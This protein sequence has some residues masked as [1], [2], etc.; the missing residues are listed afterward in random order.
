M[1]VRLFVRPS[2]PSL[3]RA[4]IIHLLADRM[5]SGQSQVNLRST[6]GQ[7]QVSLR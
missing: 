5:S 7:S 3:S 1:F 2:G 4:L 6:S